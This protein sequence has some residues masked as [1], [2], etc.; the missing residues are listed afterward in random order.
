MSTS[1]GTRVH[2]RMEEFDDGPTST[3]AF[4]FGRTPSLASSYATAD[5]QP[6]SALQPAQ[7]FPSRPRQ[8]APGPSNFT[9]ANQQPVAAAARPILR[10]V[11][12]TDGASS[13]SS[14]VTDASGQQQ[15]GIIGYNPP[16]GLASTAS[17]AE[18]L[19]VKPAKPRGAR[20]DYKPPLPAEAQWLLMTT[21]PPPPGA[22]RALDRPIESQFANQ[23]VLDQQ[24]HASSAGRRPDAAGPEAATA[25]T[26]GSVS[27]RKL[28]AA[29]L[30]FKPAHSV[31]PPPVRETRVEPPRVQLQLGSG[32]GRARSSNDYLND[33]RSLR[34]VLR[35][36]GSRLDS[37]SPAFE[38][39]RTW[40]EYLAFYAKVNTHCPAT[41]FRN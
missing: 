7:V 39:P 11:A 38:L 24:R 5:G 29:A 31:L 15:R 17:L 10:S 19:R 26:T 20:V 32:A 36:H 35:S 18:S 34:G 27:K 22:S 28:L 12:S 37:R 21:P 9:P 14:F 2:P 41:F 23:L 3:A 6:P 16:P 8:P 13:V 25:A 40:E 1:G 33:P 30:G 4:S